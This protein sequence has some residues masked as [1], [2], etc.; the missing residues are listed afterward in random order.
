MKIIQYLPLFLGFPSGHVMSVT[1]VGLHIALALDNFIDHA[2]HLSLRLKTLLKI[3]VYATYFFMIMSVALSRV[4]VSTHFPHQV[5]VAAFIG[6]AVTFAVHKVS[7]YQD[8]SSS[9]VC[10]VSSITMLIVAIV[11][12]K[13]IILSGYD[14]SFT[15]CLAKKWS[16]RKSW[17]HL[18]T[19]PFF[20]ITRDCGTLFGL[21]MSTFLDSRSAESFSCFSLLLTLIFDFIFVKTVESINI[22]HEQ[23]MFFYLRAYLKFALLPII[24]TV[25]TPYVLESFEMTLQYVLC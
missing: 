5:F 13:A 10:S 7:S 25:L 4:Y 22:F 17:V 24:I 12:Y 6:T 9:L 16:R 23:V 8:L 15:V 21:G 20:A 3:L 11:F 19:T 2:P 18:D 1:A 14:P